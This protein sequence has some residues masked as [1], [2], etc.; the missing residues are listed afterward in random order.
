MALNAKRERFCQEYLVDLNATRAALRAGYSP[1]TANE[2]GSQLLA[3]LSVAD[4]IATLMAERQERTHVSQDEVVRELALIAFSDTRHIAMD[5]L[6]RLELAADAPPQA[7]RAVQS[8]KHKK[9]VEKG[10]DVIHEA[11]YRLWSKTD[12]L[13]TLANHLGMLTDKVDLNLEGEVEVT[14][15][16][17][18]QLGDG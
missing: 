13:K 17:G 16:L 3:E 15:N 6:G 11:E 9:R 4:R 14:M 5:D 18:R 7:M 12:A 8:V 1:R 2:Q 10:G